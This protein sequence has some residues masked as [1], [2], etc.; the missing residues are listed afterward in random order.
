MSNHK[1]I[2]Q[3]F[4]SY[5]YFHHL[6]KILHR[7]LLNIREGEK[8]LLRKGPFSPPQT[9]PLFPKPFIGIYFL[10]RKKINTLE[11]SGKQLI[12]IVF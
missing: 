9:P 5:T 4:S 7:F 10:Q 1:K 12:M 3:F 6:P 2:M 11:I 8:D